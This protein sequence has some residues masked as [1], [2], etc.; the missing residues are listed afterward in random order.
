MYIIGM[1][2]SPYPTD[3]TDNEWHLL[4]PRL[5]R[6]NKPGRPRTYSWRDLLKASFYVR[7]PGCQGR[8]WPHEPQGTPI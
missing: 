4:E 1:E 2:Q 6:P 7:R 8:C 5:P 3:V